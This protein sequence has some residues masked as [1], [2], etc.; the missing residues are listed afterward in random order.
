MRVAS[1]SGA[2]VALEDRELLE[3]VA[4][5][6][7]SIPEGVLPLPMDH[8][9]A[10]HVMARVVC[11]LFPLTLTVGL[12]AGAYLHSWGIT[13]FNNVIDPLPIGIFPNTPILV[14]FDVS[15]H[16]YRAR[17]PGDKMLTAWADVAVT[18]ILDSLK[19]KSTTA[20]SGTS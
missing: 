9:I 10:R 13:K 4:A 14:E 5:L 20:A 6:I 11:E 7:D 15:R 18:T 8:R 2:D 17:V 12:F 16:M 3:Q 1:A 19:A